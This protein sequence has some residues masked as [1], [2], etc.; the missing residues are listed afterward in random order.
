MLKTHWFVARTKSVVVFMSLRGRGGGGEREREGGGGG[1]R[2][3][4]SGRKRL[5]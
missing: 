4:R 5:K 3:R 2:R 1:E